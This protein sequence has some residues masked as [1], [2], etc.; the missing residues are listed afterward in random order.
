MPHENE[1]VHV[2][3]A[4]CVQ[5]A[6]ASDWELGPQQVLFVPYESL[7]LTRMLDVLGGDEG[8]VRVHTVPCKVK[9]VLD[10]GAGL[11]YAHPPMR[12]GNP[13]AQG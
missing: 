6:N 11:V 1:E 7:G 13:H 4:L 9:F 10:V 12:E 3:L 2:R 8:L 5:T